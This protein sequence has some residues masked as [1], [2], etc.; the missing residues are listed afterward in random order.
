MHSGT[1]YFFDYFSRLSFDDINNCFDSS[2]Q[3]NNK[4]QIKLIY[5]VIEEINKRYVSRM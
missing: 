1:S 4:E 2:E 3:N 5:E